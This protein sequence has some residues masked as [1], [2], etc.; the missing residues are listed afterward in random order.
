MTMPGTHFTGPR[1]GPICS[2][3]NWAG[4]GEMPHPKRARLEFLA[5]SCFPLFPRIVLFLRHP[6]SQHMFKYLILKSK[7]VWKLHTSSYEPECLQD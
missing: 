3:F 7:S 4:C 6:C 5:F 1:F 2:C